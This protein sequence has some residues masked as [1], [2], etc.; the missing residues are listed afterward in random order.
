MKSLRAIFFIITI[1]T[2][3]QTSTVTHIPLGTPANGA[4]VDA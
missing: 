2:A 4:Y 3:A 1:A